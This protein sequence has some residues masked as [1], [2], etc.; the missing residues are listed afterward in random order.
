MNSPDAARPAF[1]N[2]V[3]YLLVEVVQNERRDRA[4]TSPEISEQGLPQKAWPGPFHIARG[5]Q[6][7]E[8]VFRRRVTF[9][10]EVGLREAPFLRIARI[11][12]TI[13]PRDRE[14]GEWKSLVESIKREKR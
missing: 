7:L 5:G 1:E 3:R 9:D 6:H 10:G 11:S 2:V 8:R 14:S 12:D 13:L 4:L